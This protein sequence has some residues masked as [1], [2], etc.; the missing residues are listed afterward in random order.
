M[1]QTS[2]SSASRAGEGD[3]EAPMSRAEVDAKL[4]EYES[5]RDG[6]LR[7][8]LATL[9]ARRDTVAEELRDLQA[10]QENTAALLKVG[11]SLAFW[12]PALSSFLHTST[13]ACTHTSMHNYV[14]TACLG[15]ASLHRK[16]N[17]CERDGA[18]RSGR[19]SPERC[20]S[21]PTPATGSGHV[22]AHTPT[23]LVWTS[24]LPQD[25]P[26]TLSGRPPQLASF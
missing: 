1:P 25:L 12:S 21:L 17:L 22:P 16:R 13:H 6:V 2:T 4:R 7:R 3:D 26:Q 24:T 19:R 10:L 23:H 11:V 5:F 9:E 8:D 15:T 14:H 20:S 18:E